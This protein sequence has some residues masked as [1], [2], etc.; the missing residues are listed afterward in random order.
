MLSFAIR[1]QLGIVGRSDQ[2]R[3]RR[4]FRIGKIIEHH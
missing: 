3:Q 1:D 4:L 2:S